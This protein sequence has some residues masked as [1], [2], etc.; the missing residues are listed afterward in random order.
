[1]MAMLQALYCVV[2]QACAIIAK[3]RIEQAN[4]E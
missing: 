3:T 1:V 4:T 2:K